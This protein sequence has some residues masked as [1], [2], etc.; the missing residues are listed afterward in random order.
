MRRWLIAT[1]I[2]LIV[3]LVG[4]AS[5][6]TSRDT[7]AQT[8]TA[9]PTTVSVTRGD[10]QELVTASGKLVN[11][12]KTA[13]SM[14]AGGQLATVSVRPGDRVKQ[15]QVLATLDIRDLEQA[16]AQAGQTYLIQQATY[17]DTL[18]PGAATIA[19]ARA[20]VN[21]ANAAYQAAQQKYATSQDQ[22]TVSCF[23]LQE[24]ADAVGRTRDAYEAIAHDLRGW[25]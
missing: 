18:Q 3:I 16:L 11:T 9:Q 12:S 6:F 8:N 17:S 7:P 13:L 25:I 14:G 1:A 2:G 22:I 24:A 10:V 4:A 21:N 19:P 20:A 15:G 23:N 5:Y